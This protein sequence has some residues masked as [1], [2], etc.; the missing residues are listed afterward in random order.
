M[1]AALICANLL[2]YACF[3]G[4]FKYKQGHNIVMSIDPTYISTLSQYNH[5]MNK[6]NTISNAS[7]ATCQKLFR[8]HCCHDVLV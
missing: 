3:A 7:L 2:F 1:A 5:T 4:F 6:H 8:I